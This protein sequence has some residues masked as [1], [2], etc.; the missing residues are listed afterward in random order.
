[1]F[2]VKC[3]VE[4]ADSERSCPLCNTPVYYPGLPAAVSTYPQYK[5]VGESTSAKGINFLIA[6]GMALAVAICILCDINMNGHIEW[7]DYV[8]G[9]AALFYLVVFLPAW[10]SRPSPAIFVPCDFLGAALFLCYINLK[11]D[12]DWFVTF[13]MPVTAFIALIVCSVVIL[14]YYLRAGYL[15][16]FGGASILFAAFF[17]VMELLMHLTFGI[18]HVMLWSMYPATAL[19]MLG[20]SLIT[21]AIVPAFRESLR[22]VFTIG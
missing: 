10:F 17:I 19:F 18:S 22:K 3:G 7:S 20:I 15:Y 21:I 2:C 16:I 8:L 14:S 6:V 5:K 11:L 1:M 12:G 9:G 4:L 13:A